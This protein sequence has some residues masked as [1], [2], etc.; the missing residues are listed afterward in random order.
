MQCGV[1]RQVTDDALRDAIAEFL[2]EL[3]A[4]ARL[5]TT[6]RAEADDLVQDTVLRMLRGATGFVVA[7]EHAGDV[8]AALRPWAITVLRNAFREGWRRRKR[9]LAHLALQPPPEDGRSGGQESIARMRDL[10]RAIADLPPALREALVLVGAQGLAHE[11]AAAICGVPVG[12][13]KARVA[14]A[15]Q[16]LAQSFGMDL[17]QP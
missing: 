15:R 2:P 12:T 17:P 11:Q 14:R 5:L 16:K 13:M 6:S 1:D 8:R 7:P 10:A 9:E 4:A 3:R